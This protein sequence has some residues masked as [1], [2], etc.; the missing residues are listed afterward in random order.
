MT[1]RDK[2]IL[3][4]VCAAEIINCAK[5]G[6][7]K[8]RIADLETQ[9]DIYASRA[10][11]WIDRAVEDEE[12]IDSMQL[13]LDALADGK[14]ELEDAGVFFCTAYCT[15]QYPHICGEGHGITASGQPIQAGVTV[16]ADQTIF[17]YGTV[18][19]IKIML[20]AHN[21][22]KFQ[23]CAQI[24]RNYLPQHIAIH[25]RKQYLAELNRKRKGGR[26]AQGDSH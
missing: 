11:H 3:A 18:L 23:G 10:Q 24:Y 1:R 15:E 6:A 5:A 26:N 9:R 8:S 20:I 21:A 16:A 13:R 7:L 17:P 22:Y 14:V 4:L 12:V 19:Y 2:A 25:V